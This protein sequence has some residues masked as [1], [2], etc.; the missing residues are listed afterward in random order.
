VLVVRGTKLMVG[1]A[2]SGSVWA[3][4]VRVLERMLRRLRHPLAAPDLDA[5]VGP[6][7]QPPREIARTASQRPFRKPDPTPSLTPYDAPSGTP[8]IPEYRQPKGTPSTER[9]SAER[10]KRF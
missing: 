4:A 10:R 8:G 7:A 3:M 6:G 2:P 5:D 9:I 1:Q